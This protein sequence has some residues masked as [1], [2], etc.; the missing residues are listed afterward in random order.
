MVFDQMELGITP[1]SLQIQNY[2]RPEDKKYWMYVDWTL[3][4][5]PKPDSKSP[6]IIFI[7]PEID[8][9]LK[10]SPAFN[11]YPFKDFGLSFYKGDTLLKKRYPKV[12]ALIK[13]GEIVFNLRSFAP[14]VYAAMQSPRLKFPS[15]LFKNSDK[16]FESKKIVAAKLLSFISDQADSVMKYN[17]IKDNVVPSYLKL[18][19]Q[20]LA[21]ASIDEK[22]NMRLKFIEFL[23]IKYTE[24]W[25]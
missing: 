2:F 8:A 16:S 24:I 22:I 15:Q 23:K 12:T 19:D 18:E 25:E 11:G 10:G 4:D 17:N 1:D 6:I 3:F 5:I 9:D 7:D 13:K 21:N 14:P 20:K